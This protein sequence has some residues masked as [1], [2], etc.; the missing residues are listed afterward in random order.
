MF[1]SLEELKLQRIPFSKTYQAGALDYHATEIRQIGAVK[2]EGSAELTGLEIRLRGHISGRVETACDRCLEAVELP[3]E[4]DFD[5]F[6]RAMSSIARQEEVEIGPD[7]L[8]V[9][10]YTGDGIELADVVVEQV[11]LFLPMKVLCRPDCK[12]LCPVCKVNR[13]L[14]PCECVESP[15]ESPFASLLGE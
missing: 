7:E 6:Y 12:G 9:G 10:F 13:N 11:N 15:A 14:N 8:D 5:L 1:I 3:V 2:V 4:C